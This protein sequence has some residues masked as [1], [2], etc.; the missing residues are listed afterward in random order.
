[1]TNRLLAGLCA[2]LLLLPATAF[3]QAAGGDDWEGFKP[4]ASGTA[5]APATGTPPPPPPTAPA[6]ANT[7]APA[8]TT[9]AKPTSTSTAPASTAAT[10]SS[11]SAASTNPATAPMTTLAP[12]DN[13]EPAPKLV[14]T[15][16]TVQPGSEPHDPSTL[17]NSLTD[18]ANLRDA[19][20]ENGQV[21]VLHVS[22]AHFGRAGMLHLSASGQYFRSNDF[23]VLDASDTRTAGVF[24]GGYNFTN[25]LQAYVN[26]TV[27][28]NT[29]TKSAPH[30]IQ[31]QGDAQV[32]LAA[33]YEVYKGLSLGLDA[34]LLL[35][36]GTG[37]QDVSRS[38]FGFAPT[39][40]VTYDF[41]ALS[42]QVPLRAHVNLGVVL[43]KTTS[44]SNGHTLTAA[45][46][47]ALQT[48]K[49][50]RFQISGALEAGLPVATPYIEYTGFIPLG[51]SD[52]I[53]PDNT[54]VSTGEAFNE[55]LG[56]G[57]RVTAVQDL[58]INAAVDLGLARTVAYGIPATMPW[59][60]LF[61]VTYTVDPFGTGSNKV[62]EKTY[63]KQAPAALAAAPAPTTGRVE[64]TALDGVTGKPI[65]GVLVAF[66]DHDLPPVATDANRGHFQSYELAPGAVKLNV[67]H[68]GYQPATADATVEAGK[69]SSVE[70]RLMP[71]AKPVAAAMG[72]LIVKVTARKKPVA[73]KV[74]ATAGTG[75][76][77]DIPPNAPAT[78]LPAGHYTITVLADGFDAQSKEVDVAAEKTGTESFSLKAAKAPAA[79]GVAAPKKPMVV[80]IKNKI[81]IKQQVHFATN[82]AVILRD[83]YTLLDQVA[84]AIKTNGLKH[85][86]VEGHTDNVGAKDANL[87]LS[88]DRAAAVRAYLLKKG[89]GEDALEAKG[90]GDSKPIA[91]NMTAKGREMN[92]RVEFTITEK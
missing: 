26:Y 62:V 66:L 53:A 45:E 22:S 70:V 40:L 82:K 91:P 49:Y 14:S 86:V 43:D 12:L 48:Q 59:N 25:W 74:T 39:A 84:D 67:Q 89:I 8:S 60:L 11:T 57:V 24:A 16:E 46:E 71:E 52:L 72:N 65:S 31:D 18:P 88:Q 3:A 30:L 17:H 36:P 41:H 68:E 6:P 9:S 35:S 32:G 15:K 64:G 78:A 61:G 85:V 42:P 80:V 63:E 37:N 10:T 56:L 77:I 90:F 75:A 20:G 33:G 58:T 47:F 2:A 4:A 21:G 34:R 50:N 76:P 87:K 29:N 44:F 38:V 23:P 79:D 92:R 5:P 69:V 54:S 13:K 27:A 55:S 1:M 83:S 51:A 7:T 73:A 28:A 19:A 81:V